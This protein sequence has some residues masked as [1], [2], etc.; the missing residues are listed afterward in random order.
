M[1][2]FTNA[3]NGFKTKLGA[4]SKGAVN[5]YQRNSLAN[6]AQFGTGSRMATGLMQ[7][8]ISGL[9]AGWD[10][11]QMKGRSGVVG[12]M[13]GMV[14]GA[15]L[16][17]AAQP[18]GWGGAGAAGGAAAGLFGG[19]R[20]GNFAMAF[21]RNH[22]FVS[23]A[24]AGL[25]GPHPNMMNRA[26]RGMSRAYAKAGSAWNTAGSSVGTAGHSMMDKAMKFKSGFMNNRA[27][28]NAA[29]GA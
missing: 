6:R 9:K 7:D 28:R 25:A 21:A 29:A 26:K 11:S 18:D 12:S 14:G 10:A 23:G 13:A 22:S 1:G 16:G 27:A 4:V 15:G 20:A 24:R 19:A 5:A 3:V 2:M 8:G 17:Y